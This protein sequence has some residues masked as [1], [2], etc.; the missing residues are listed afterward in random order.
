M[1]D[2]FPFL[3]AADIGLN[4]AGLAFLDKEEADSSSNKKDLDPNLAKVHLD[5]D[6]LNESRKAAGFAPFETQDDA[7]KA[8]NQGNT[9]KLKFEAEQKRQESK[10]LA[11]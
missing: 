5:L 4:I 6:R 7:I 11:A 2:F 10:T 9:T 1:V 3:M 8:L